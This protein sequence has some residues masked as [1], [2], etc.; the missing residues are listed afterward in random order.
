MKID[1]RNLRFATAKWLHDIRN[2]ADNRN[3]RDPAS[4]NICVKDVCAR[5]RIRTQA[6]A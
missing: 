1:V 3:V 4:S 6:M 5:R 2:I